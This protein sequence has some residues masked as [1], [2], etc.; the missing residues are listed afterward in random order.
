MAGGRYALRTEQL[1][2]KR[3]AIGQANAPAWL[4]AQLRARRRGEPVVSPRAI[5]GWIAWRDARATTRD[6]AR[7][8]A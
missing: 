6:A 1:L 4:V 3:D 2:T 7:V 8:K 5:T